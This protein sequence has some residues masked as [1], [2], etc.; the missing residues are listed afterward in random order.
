MK[1]KGVTWASPAPA[2]PNGA[3]TARE[4]G[5]GLEGQSVLPK[6]PSRKDRALTTCHWSRRECP[7]CQVALPPRH[8]TQNTRCSEPQ[9]AQDAWRAGL[10]PRENVLTPEA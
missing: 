2:R 9:K 1:A 10:T 4:A 6:H 8:G 3:E 7:V 5:S